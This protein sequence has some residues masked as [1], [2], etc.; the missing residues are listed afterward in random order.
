MTCVPC[1][2]LPVCVQMCA[3]YVCTPLCVCM[4]LIMISMNY[5]CGVMLF[6]QFSAL[7]FPQTTLQR[8]V[9]G[10]LAVNK[11]K[12]IDF[13]SGQHPSAK[14]SPGSELNKLPP[15]TVLRSALAYCCWLADGHRRSTGKQIWNQRFEGNSSTVLWK[16]TKTYLANK[17]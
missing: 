4:R 12:L 10:H 9:S 8:R 6:I 5:A 7:I 13:N 17:S 2:Y 1:L 15:G 14:H 3:C 11:L 16:K